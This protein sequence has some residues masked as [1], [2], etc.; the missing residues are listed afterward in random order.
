MFDRRVGR[1]DFLF[2]S[3]KL[4]AAAAAAGPFFMAAE[5]AA[6]AMR[7]ST[8][9]DPI[10]TS[11]VNAAKKYSGI[12]LTKTNEAGLQALDDQN[13]TGP[14]WEKLTGIK[15]KVVASPF[16]Q[17]YSKA[18]SEHIAQSGALD[19]IDGSPVWM[20]DFADRGVIVP[21]SDWIKKYKAQATLNDYHPLYRSLMDYKGKTWG[22]FDDG[23]VWALY[24]RKDVFGDP[25]LKKAY[26]A[27]FKKPLR[28]P[29]SWAEFN[30]TSQ[31]ITDQMAPKIYGGG[32]GR[33]L[34]NPGNQFYFF[35]IFRAL[36]GQFFDPKTMKAEI[37]NATGQKAMQ[38]IMDEIKASPPGI[39]KLT[40]VDSWVLW[41]NGKTAMMYAWP[42]TGRISENY[43]QADKAFAFLPKSKIVGK[44]GYALVPNKN[45]E[46]AGSFIKYT[47]A[48]SKNKEAAYLFTQWATS[49][50]ISLQRVQLPY[51]LRDPYRISHYKS[52]QYASRWPAAKLYLRTLNEAANNSVLDP[53]MS[54]A[55]DYANALDRGMTAIYAGK[56]IKSGLDEVASEWD[57]VT[58][59]LGEDKQRE[60]WQTFLTYMGATAQNT[61][62]AKGKAVRL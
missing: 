62:A 33:A 23:D 53:I 51:T 31:F 32:E 8:G 61:V 56:D 28:V 52:K 46:H 60:S 2:D 44:V 25:K 6:A 29:Q 38:L 34:G 37:N 54:G 21:I 17:I 55:A 13:F 57:G 18:V 39:L 45:G 10:A 43:A 58:K 12:T 5:Q 40:F 15:V 59:R 11:A 41:L 27:K 1:K 16:P 36:G 48:D 47:A 49:P 42:P 24:Y 30:Q 9:G 20:P 35:Q 3:A 19:V 7:A 4:L 22:Y 14:L 50:S 26:Q